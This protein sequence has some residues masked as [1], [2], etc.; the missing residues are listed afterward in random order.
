VVSNLPVVYVRGYAGGDRGIEKAV[1]DPFYGFNEG[2]VHVRV[3]VSGR[4]SFYQFESPLLRLMIDGGRPEGGAPH[5]GYQL[6]VHG[7][8]ERYLAEAEPGSV[9]QASIWVHRFYDVSAESLTTQAATLSGDENSP[10]RHREFDL[11]SAAVSLLELITNV[12]RATGAPRVHLVAHSMG[13]LIC[14]CLIQKVLPDRGEHG[15]DHIDRLFTYGTPHGGIHF[16]IG[17]GLF[18]RIRDA[19]DINGASIFGPERMYAYLTPEAGRADRVPDGWV[20]NRIPP[21]LFPGDR[22]FCLVGTNPADYD[23]AFGLSSK[24]V[25][26]KSDGLVQIESAYL[27]GANFAFVHRSHSGRYGLVNSEEG[28]QNLRRF[29]FGDLSVSADLVNYTLPGEPDAGMTWQADVRLSVRGMPIVMHEQVAAHQC[30]VQLEWSGDQD[31]A[32]KPTP[33]VTTFLSSGESRPGTA[34]MR[35]LL[36]FRILSLRERGGIFSFGDH[37][38]Q[39][40]DFDDM[41]VVD[42]EP[43]RPGESPRGWAAWASEIK[44]PLR[45][46]APSDAQLMTDEE[47]AEGAWLAHIELPQRSAAFLGP[48]AR[49]QLTVTPTETDPSTSATRGGSGFRD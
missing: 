8:Q 28:Y 20:A 31:S 5:Q 2:S 7:S 46:Y 19:V 29:L 40:A 1:E 4:P 34:T 47:P 11:E 23:V 35:Y 17:G 32:G 6:L 3:G 9:P 15:L 48:D 22:V 33:L 44:E 24:A 41:L 49:I 42:I 45:D 12:K 10:L 21:E 13:G 37:L 38:E 30:P 18:E 16:D 25:G 39:S 43:A 14:R 36:Q 26:P 27:K